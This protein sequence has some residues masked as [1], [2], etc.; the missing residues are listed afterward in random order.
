MDS[1]NIFKCMYFH[2]FIHSLMKYYIT[3]C[4]GATSVLGARMREP[5]TEPLSS[6]DMRIYVL[7]CYMNFKAGCSLA[8]TGLLPWTLA[9]F[10]V[11]IPEL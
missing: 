4:K 5:Y 11:A 7:R 10:P 3:L 9:L 1:L 2:M 6:E 8:K